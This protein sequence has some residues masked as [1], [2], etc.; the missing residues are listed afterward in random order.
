MCFCTENQESDQLHCYSSKQVFY[1]LK[2]NFHLDFQ[3]WLHIAGHELI[4]E[5]LLED[6][7]SKQTLKATFKKTFDVRISS[8]NLRKA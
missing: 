4:L 3:T 7:G 1:N 8:T 2:L 6:D 5:V